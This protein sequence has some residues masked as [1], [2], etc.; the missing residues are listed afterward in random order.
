M[1]AAAQLTKEDDNREP[2]MN[3]KNFEM[4]QRMVSSV[5]TKMEEKKFQN[6]WENSD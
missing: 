4:I 6:V 2:D 3:A 1:K 5:G